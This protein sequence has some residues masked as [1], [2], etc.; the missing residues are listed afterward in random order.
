MQIDAKTPE[1]FRSLQKGMEGRY[2]KP[3]YHHNGG[4]FDCANLALSCRYMG[5]AMAYILKRN[6]G[7]RI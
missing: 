1:I 4:Y 5:A 2:E 6:A 3:S 7:G